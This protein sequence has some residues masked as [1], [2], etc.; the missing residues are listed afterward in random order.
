MDSCEKIVTFRGESGNGTR[1]ILQILYES[2]VLRSEKPDRS[3]FAVELR[4][5]GTGM[6]IFNAINP[7]HHSHIGFQRFP[8]FLLK[9]VR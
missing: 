9:L 7:E 5:H 4:R 8:K 6:A 1:P 2:S 3:T